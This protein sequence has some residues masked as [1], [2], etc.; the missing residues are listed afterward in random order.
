MIL[1][2]G[3]TFNPIH[4]GH[5]IPLQN[6]VN[7]TNPDKLIYVPCHIPPHK[8]AP[9]VSSKDRLEMT[10]LAVLNSEFNCPVDVSD[11]ELVQSGKSYT[12]LTLRHY[13]AL[14]DK[15]NIAFVIGMDSLLS[16]HTWYEWQHIVETT[17]LYVLVRPGY[18]LDK[19]TLHP[20]IAERIGESITLFNN[21]EVEL[22]SSDLRQEFET[23]SSLNVAIETGN[24]KGKIPDSV[25]TYIKQNRLYTNAKTND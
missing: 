19:E 25:L 4:F 9:S 3:G 12:A 13:T 23:Y 15:Q 7:H 1:L 8:A 17:H 6:L 24:I 14:Y 20:T 18:V 10:K 5:I 22:A 11:Y 16:L 21:T 2:Y